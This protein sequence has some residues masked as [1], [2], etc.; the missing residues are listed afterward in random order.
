LKELPNPMRNET[1]DTPNINDT[2]A[3]EISVKLDEKG[4]FCFKSSAGLWRIWHNF[5][6]DELDRGVTMNQHDIK[7]YV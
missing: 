3:D 6:P 1:W 4:N 2:L 7:A 5:S